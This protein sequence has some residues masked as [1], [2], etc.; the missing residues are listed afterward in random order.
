MQL[1][2]CAC[3]SRG[4]STTTTAITAAS[5]EKVFVRNW[6]ASI[7]RLRRHSSPDQYLVAEEKYQDLPAWRE[8]A[9]KAL[10]KKRL[11]DSLRRAIV[12][13]PI[14]YREVLFLRDVKNLDTAETAWI[15]NVTA[16]AVRARLLRAR[17]QVYGTL[18]SSLLMRTHENSLVDCY[19]LLRGTE[20]LAIR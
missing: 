10:E 6:T 16:G 8:I 7:T 15:L 12:S 1:F 14:Q 13:L 5:I 4:M 19:R 11:G 2:T 20:S 9:W 3:I 18:M 17:M